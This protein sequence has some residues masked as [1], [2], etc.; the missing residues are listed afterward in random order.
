MMSKST[1]TTLT[2]QNE[3]LRAALERV[4]RNDKTAYR[5]G[6]KDRRPWDGLNAKEADGGDIFLTPREIARAALKAK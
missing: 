2:A 1:P 5:G 3:K 6:L 4:M